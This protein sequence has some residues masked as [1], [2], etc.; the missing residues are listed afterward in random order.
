VQRTVGGQHVVDA[1]TAAGDPHRA[2]VHPQPARLAG[3]QAQHCPKMQLA[4]RLVEH[5]QRA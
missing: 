1:L 5:L 3:L 2:I 4:R